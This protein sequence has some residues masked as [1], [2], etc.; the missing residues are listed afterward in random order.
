MGVIKKLVKIGAFDT[1]VP[2]RKALELR[3]QEEDVKPAERC[4]FWKLE[5]NEH[6]LPCEYD[7]SGEPL[8]IGKTGKTMKPKPPPKR[9]T[10]GCRQYIQ[11]P[12]PADDGVVPYTEAEIRERE[13]EALGVYLSSSP[14]D[15]IDPEDMALLSNANEIQTAPP[16]CYLT[17]VI[18]TKMR[19][20]R[21]AKGDPMKFLTVT[22]P[23]GDMD[24]TV[25]SNTL[26][27][28]REHI[29]LGQMGLAEVSKNDR[30]TTLQVLEPI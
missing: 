24:I 11:R 25:F 22:T 10:K 12:L 18:I 20:H 26:S 27:A 4:I 5:L 3:L 8:Q 21:T 16:G 29:R 2:N 9:C 13:M 19:D 15:I 30:G 14:F 1:L 7:W 6:N 28:Y 17:A 23:S